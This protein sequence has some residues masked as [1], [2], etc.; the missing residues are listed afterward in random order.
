MKKALHLLALIYIY[1]YINI[2]FVSAQETKLD[3]SIYSPMR[4]ILAR[5]PEYLKMTQEPEYQISNYFYASDSAEYG[6]KAIP[7][8]NTCGCSDI[9]CIPPFMINGKV[10]PVYDAFGN[11]IDYL[12]VYGADERNIYYVYMPATINYNRGIVVLIHGGGWFSCPTSTWGFPFSWALPTSSESMVKDL[13]NNGYVVVSLLYRLTKYDNDLSHTTTTTTTWLDQVN[14]VKAAI[15]H[16]RSRFGTCLTKHGAVNTDKIQLIGESAGGHL[17]LQYAYKYGN[18]SYLK[19]VIPMYAP[20]DLQS[21]G[22]F[23]KNTATSDFVCGGAFDL[24]DFP[25]FFGFDV[26]DGGVYNY[27]P[28]ECPTSSNPD[29]KVFYTFRFAESAVKHAIATPTTDNDLLLNSPYNTLNT[30]HII[31]PTFVMHG[32]SDLLAPYNQTATNMRN[33]L[34]SNGGII[35]TYKFPPDLLQ[36][37]NIPTN[38][39][40]FNSKHVIKLYKNLNHG[41]ELKSNTDRNNVRSEV[42]SWLNQH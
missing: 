33:A 16:I 19:S 28:F 23:L 3:M 12:G 13:L 1:I 15:N 34:I 2:S 26:N 30:N 29:Y 35:N 18:P 42:I 21:Y 36:Q 41:W 38:L 5:N 17:A 10:A 27:F 14:D 32:L 39:S 25:H 22:N 11:R 8:T 31:I 20:T 9:A 6:R 7:P 24:S 40:T 4:D 37:P